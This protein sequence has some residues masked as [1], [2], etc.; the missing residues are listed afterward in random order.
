MGHEH[1]HDHFDSDPTY[2]SNKKGIR[3]LKISFLGLIGTAVLQA[4]IY[5]YSKSVA[6]LADTLHNFMDAFTALPLW[7]AFL[8]SQRKP[9]SKFTY[10]YNR[11]EDLVGLLITILIFGTAFFV[12]YDSI[13][14]LKSG[15][16]PTHLNWVIAAS[17]IGFLGNEWVARYRINVGKEINS[18]A[19]VADGY[20]ARADGYTSLGVLLGAVG[21]YLGYP[22]A[23]PLVGFLIS[24]AILK[25]GYT[26]GRQMITRLM[27]AISPDIVKG[28]HEEASK[29][30]GVLDVLDIRARNSGR[31][32]RVDLTIEVNQKITVLE[33]H[34]I[35][36]RVQHALQKKF[37]QI[38]QPNIHV[39]P[40]GHRG[41]KHHF[42]KHHTAPHDNGHE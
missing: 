1:P 23:D 28:V 9:N 3:A 5:Y 13:T 8:L 7:M 38:V 25:I 2:L 34:E 26:S 21:V 10:G 19:L 35:A 40:E 41:E 6:L 37:P 12:V 36:V 14:K 17:I 42:E 30:Q 18:A 22:L 27:D 15:F 20:H 29:V 24:I 33:G 16:I 39:D 31:Q 32:L 4:I 11:L